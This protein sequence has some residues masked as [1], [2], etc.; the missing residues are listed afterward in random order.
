MYE[1]EKPSLKHCMLI[2]SIGSLFYFGCQ[3]LTT[4]LV[5]RLSGSFEAAGN[6]AIAMSIANIFTPF[7]LFRMRTYQVSDIN[8]SV[9][10]S[11]YM[12]FRLL[13]CSI[14]MIACLVY[15]Y[16]T[17]G[18]D[19]FLSILLF[20]IFKFIEQIADVL[21]GLDQKKGRLDLAGISLFV[22]GLVSLA[23]F[24]AI[25]A[26]T[27]NL[28]MALL[29]EIISTA[30]VVFSFDVSQSKKFEQI[31]PTF[32]FTIF[33]KLFKNCAVV[34]IASVA[35]GAV[36]TVPKQYLGNSLGSSAL[37]IY[38]SIASP[39]AIIQLGASYL[40][41]PLLGTFSSDYLNTNYG[42]F[43]NLLY[44]ITLAIILLAGVASIV[45]IPIAPSFL[46]LL[47]GKGTDAYCYLVLPMIICSALTG[48]YL[49]SSDLLL[50]I[51]EVKINSMSG[52]L[53]LLVAIPASIIFI[54]AFGMN[55]VNLAGIVAYSTGSVINLSTVIKLTKGKQREAE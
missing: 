16:F 22:R 10:T 41:N 33:I 1:K 37:G 53:T 42:S 17:C 5:V 2:N 15:S 9:T 24:V 35:A 38:S 51:R 19:S 14:A 30:L 6:L 23:A 26:L 32:D 48:Y 11:Q 50:S 46:N 52:F 4:I 55:G 28:E 13:T 47:F 27:K 45:F 43:R 54:R 49:F 20:L 12:G 7:A 25:L 21:N 34:V 36:M 31:S 40:Y 8:D 39:L 18:S 29:G 3:W 44:K